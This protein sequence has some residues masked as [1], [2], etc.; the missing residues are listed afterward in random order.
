[1]L[2]S[3]RPRPGGSRAAV[4]AAVVAAAAGP[5]AWLCLQA[6]FTSSPRTIGSHSQAHASAVALRGQAVTEAAGAASVAD[7][8][9]AALAS[10][11]LAR[12]SDGAKVDLPSLWDTGFFGFGGDRVVVAFLRHFG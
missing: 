9:Y 10:V 5:G 12:A 7:G 3:R 2:P 4:L 6:A 11:P 8:A 1:M